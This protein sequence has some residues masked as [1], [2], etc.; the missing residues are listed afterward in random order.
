MHVVLFVLFFLAAGCANTPTDSQARPDVPATAVKA[1]AAQERVFGPLV[2][3]VGKRFRGT[4]GPGS[5]VSS[6][7]VQAWSWTL[8]GAA[9]R[10]DHALEDG[11]YGGITYVYPDRQSGALAYVYITNS[12]FRTEG[13]FKLNP[14]GSWTA[15]EDVIGQGDISRVRSTG[16][17]QDDG[18]LLSQGTYLKG[19]Q[20]VPGP[21]FRYVETDEPLPSL[22]PPEEK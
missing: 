6:A 1:S 19:E 16:R 8:G 5:S 22:S 9:I 14:D 13:R 7:D 21:S 11:S 15:E 12:G 18:T 17:I 20:W 10:M 4:P 2:A 3:L